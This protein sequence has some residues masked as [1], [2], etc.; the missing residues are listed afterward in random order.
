M[1]QRA[2]RLWAVS[3]ATRTFAIG[4]IGAEEKNVYEIV[5][6]SQKAGLKAVK[7][8]IDC[9]KIDDACSRE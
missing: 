9:K 1:A 8:N 7:P 5:K 6:E 4:K 2:R 3:D